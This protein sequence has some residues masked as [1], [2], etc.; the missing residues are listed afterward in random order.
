MYRSSSTLSIA[1]AFALW[2]T[3][4]QA[5]QFTDQVA[6]RYQEL[7]FDYVEIKEG[8]DQLKVEA[9]RGDRKIEVIYDRATGKILKQ[10][11]ERAT[12]A[13][14]ARNG[15]D[16]DTRNEN[17]L[18]RDD[19]DDDESDDEDD[20]NDEGDDDENDESDDD[21]DG[22]SDDDDESDDDESDDE[23]DDDESD[24]SDESD[25]SDESDDDES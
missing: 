21:E 12:L 24:D 5:D 4:T 6:Q 18:D 8:I 14:M 17:F 2:S 16:I 1:V 15:V 7:G 20:E 22:R 11:T 19:F 3:A 13:E 9:I 23:D 10:E 25:E